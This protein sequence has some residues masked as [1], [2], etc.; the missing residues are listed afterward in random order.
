[1]N[2]RPL[3]ARFHVSPQI[4]VEDVRA[5]A[6]LG[7]SVLVSNRPDGEQPDQPEAEA[8]RAAAEAAGLAFHHIPMR[9]AAVGHD[10]LAAFRQ[11]L[12]DAPGPVLGFCRSGMRTTVLWALSQA[13]D[14]PV[15]NILRAAAGAG[16]DLAGLR[17]VLDAAA[18]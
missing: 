16:Y 2:I 13:G 6:A 9:G 17:P 7:Y 10:D 3:D 8:L 15:D 18:S 4:T 5:A 14:Q 11:V 1:M 12:E